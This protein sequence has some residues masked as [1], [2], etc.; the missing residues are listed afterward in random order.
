M[1]EIL[2]EMSE[3]RQQNARMEQETAHLRLQR[4]QAEDREQGLRDIVA[5]Y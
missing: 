3:L 4:K 1:A 2:A 5:N